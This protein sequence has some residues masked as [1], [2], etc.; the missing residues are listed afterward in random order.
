MGCGEVDGD[1]RSDILM[2]NGND[3]NVRYARCI[4]FRGDCDW[5]RVGSTSVALDNMRFGDFDGGCLNC[6]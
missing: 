6:Q 2:K 5:E 4:P 1:G 3:M